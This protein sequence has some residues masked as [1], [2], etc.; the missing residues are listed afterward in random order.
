M[1]VMWYTHFFDM[2]T[3]GFFERFGL[4]RDYHKGGYGSFALEFHTRYLAELRQEDEVRV[5]SRAIARSAKLLHFIHFMERSRDGELCATQETPGIHIDLATRRSAPL[6][7]QI[8][9]AYDD[10]IAKHN[11]VEWEA[12]LSG[13][14]SL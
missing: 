10:L 3:W 9:V 13:A 12:P 1:N 8:A 2:A 7:K 4:G 14:I 11:Q 6:P 5:Y